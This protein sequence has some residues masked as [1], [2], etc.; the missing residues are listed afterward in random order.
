MKLIS[1]RN[2][3]TIMLLIRILKMP[4]KYPYFKIKLENHLLVSHSY[5]RNDEKILFLLLKI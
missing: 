1:N 2:S 3:L 5:K 4:N